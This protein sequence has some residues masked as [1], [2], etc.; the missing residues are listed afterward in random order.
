VLTSQQYEALLAI[1]NHVARGCRLALVL[2]YKTGHR[3]GAIRQLRWS[4]VDF[5]REVIRWRLQHDKIG[6]EHE[7]PMRPAAPDSVVG[8]AA[9]GASNQ[10]SVDLSRPEEPE[11]SRVPIPSKLLGPKQLPP[12]PGRGWHSCR[13]TFATELKAAPL[14]DLC[15][16]ADGGTR[17][18]S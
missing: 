8:C 17:K 2:A 16:R 18:Q 11:G 15:A 13:R 10:R 5:E 1:A 6:R 12:E 7:T 3:I 14:K 4:D 9:A